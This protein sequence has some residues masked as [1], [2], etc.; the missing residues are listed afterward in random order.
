MIDNKSILDHFYELEHIAGQLEKEGR[1]MDESI[2]KFPQS[3]WDHKKNLIHK[4][5]GVSLK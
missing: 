5:D 4:K 1:K 3:W 2:D